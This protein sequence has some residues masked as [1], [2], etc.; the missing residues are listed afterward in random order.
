MSKLYRMAAVTA[1]A[2]AAMTGSAMAQNSFF[3][4]SATTVVSQTNDKGALSKLEGRVT[5]RCL[6]DQKD[7]G[8]A[9]GVLTTS[10]T[11]GTQV[12]NVCAGDVQVEGRITAR[13]GGA[14]T[15]CAPAIVR[16]PDS[17]WKSGIYYGHFDSVTISA[18]SVTCNMKVE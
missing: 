7:M 9:V 6:S 14:T 11:S 10:T 15:S 18:T 13:S 1:L 2:L 17:G 3:N 5:F 4:G 16:H 12:N 8:G